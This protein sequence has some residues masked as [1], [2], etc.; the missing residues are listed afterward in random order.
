MDQMFA[1]WRRDRSL[2]QMTLEELISRIKELPPDLEIQAIWHPHSY[3][4]YYSDLA[5]EPADGTVKAVELLSIV[6]DCLGETYQGYKGGDYVMD[7]K[8]PLWMAFYGD[9][10]SKI[11]S[12]GDD[13]KF[14]T[15]KDD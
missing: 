12:L 9:C 6:K 1:Q 11:I 4:G 14:K 5:F 2:S 10:G 13:G 3:R 15:A 7:K 8:T